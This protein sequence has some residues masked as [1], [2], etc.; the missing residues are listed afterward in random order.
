MGNRNAVRGQGVFSPPLSRGR[1]SLPDLPPG[2]TFDPVLR[3]LFPEDREHGGGK[4]SPGGKS[5][6]ET[7]PEARAGKKTPCPSLLSYH[8]ISRK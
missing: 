4:T 3:A 5:V 6:E 8:I 7:F 2:E 1:C